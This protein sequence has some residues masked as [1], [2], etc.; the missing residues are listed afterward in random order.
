[1]MRQFLLVA[2]TGGGLLRVDEKAQR[3]GL[4]PWIAEARSEGELLFGEDD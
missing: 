3:G 4:R 1:M 2:I